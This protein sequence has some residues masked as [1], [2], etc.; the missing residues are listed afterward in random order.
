MTVYEN[1]FLGNEIKKGSVID[2]FDEIEKARQLLSK[3]K[4]ENINPTAKVKDLSVSM[5]QLVEIAKALS[6]NLK[7]KELQLFL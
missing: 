4:G 6:K 1:I 5:Q 2:I 7:N 3:V